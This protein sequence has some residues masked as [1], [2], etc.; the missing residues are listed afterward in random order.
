MNCSGTGICKLNGNNSVRR[1]LLKKNCHTTIAQIAAG[2]NGKLS[3]F[4]FRELLC[5]KLYRRHF[6]KGVLS[7]HEPCPLPEEL[8]NSLDIKATQLLPGD[9]E[10]LECDGYFRIDLDLA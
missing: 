5:V 6:H 9:Y 10:V 4:F 7:M 3:L 1:A 8:S 2:P